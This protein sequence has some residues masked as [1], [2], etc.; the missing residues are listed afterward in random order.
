[1]NLT[2]RANLLKSLRGAIENK[3]KKRNPNF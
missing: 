1:M 2:T 3:G